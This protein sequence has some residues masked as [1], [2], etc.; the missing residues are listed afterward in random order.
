MRQTARAWMCI[1]PVSKQRYEHMEN[2]N[3]STV[4]AYKKDGIKHSFPDEY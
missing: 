3:L 4:L 2:V 1:S